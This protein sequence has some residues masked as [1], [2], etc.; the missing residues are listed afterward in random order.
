LQ[1]SVAAYF[2]ANAPKYGSGE[3]YKVGYS[4]SPLGRC[5]TFQNH[6]PGD[7]QFEWEVHKT[8]A[9][10]GGPAP[11]TEIAIVGEN[12]LKAHLE[13]HGESLG[14]EFFFAS[15]GVVSDAWLK[16]VKAIR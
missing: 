16:A 5:A 14:R 10:D 6:L 1:G 15:S 9:R 12:E 11:N 4:K 2:G 13:A 8:T 7:G 3:I